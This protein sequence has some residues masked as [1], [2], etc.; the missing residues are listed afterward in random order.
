MYKPHAIL[1]ADS[2][3]FSHH[4]MLPPWAR[5]IYANFT[6]RSIVHSPEFMKEIVVFGNQYVIN[7]LHDY[8]A[9]EFF[10]RP[11]GEIVNASLLLNEHFMGEYDI[12]HF[13]ELHN[14]WYLPIE[15]K[16]IDEWET[17]KPWI[18]TLVRR[19]TDDRFPWLVL[20]LETIINNML[21]K[22]MVNA[23][24]AK[25]MKDMYVDFANETGGEMWFTEFQ[26]HD[27]SMRWIAWLDAAISS[28]MAHLT[29]FKWT[30]TV[31]AIDAINYYYG[32]KWDLW[33]SVP[34]CFPDWAE[35]LTDRWFVDFSDLSYDDKVAEYHE[36]WFISFVNPSKIHEYDFDWDLVNVKWWRYGQID[37][38]VTPDH[39]VIH[40]DSNNKIKINKAKDLTYVSKFIVSWKW[41]YWSNKLSDYGRLLIAFQADWSYSTRERQYT[42]E[43]T[44]TMPMRFPTLKK[45]RK[46]KRLKEI[47]E[48]LWFDYTESYYEGKWCSF[49]VQVPVNDILSKTFDWV[50]I[51]NVTEKWAKEFIDELQYRDGS[52]SREWY[53]SYSSVIK[54]NIDVVQA[55]CSIWGHRTHYQVYNDKRVNRKPLH[56]LWIK[57][58]DC[59]YNV[60]SWADISNEPYKWKVRCVTVPTG[61]FVARQNGRVI[62][63]GNS[64]HS[65]SSSCIAT[66]GEEEMFKYFME[67]YP[68]GIISIV[69]DTIDFWNVIDDI[70]PRLKDII[71]ARDGKVVIRPDS[72]D[73]FDIVCW[74]DLKTKWLVEKL[75]DIFGWSLTSEGYIVLH[76]NIWCIYWDS[77]RYDTARDILSWLKNKGFASNNV[78]FWHWSYFYQL[79]TRDNVWWASKATHII[80]DGEWIDI[81][82]DPKTEW[83]MGKKS[84]KWML[85]VE[86]E[87]GEFILHEEQTEEQYDQWELKIRYINWLFTNTQDFDE[88]RQN[89][90][91]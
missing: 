85:R 4:K 42:W 40:L 51:D 52:V 37:F 16:G 61:M 69:S 67:Q 19:N 20:W 22:P 10:N 91:K 27:F 50:E 18:P 58:G 62:V 68:T 57:L 73:P 7:W 86:K 28:W 41:E 23:S 80:V 66:M 8:F 32:S 59:T 43:K 35:V 45:E 26:W 12:P 53:I 25:C 79:N 84:A 33:Y 76:E 24:L 63:T 71:L 39:R 55:L 48:R 54:E 5:R 78:V 6:P 15:F 56:C 47:L 75:W 9:K 90:N 82:K 70:L 3:K 14:L 72:W 64:E 38:S 29:S 46:I 81:F 2:Y 60:K 77:I 74:P 36:E 11:I 13:K 30:D 34:A 87:D 88:I 83:R 89:L 49:R 31:V 21:W 44:W 1:L 17:V 65:V